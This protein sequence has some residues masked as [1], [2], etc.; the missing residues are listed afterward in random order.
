MSVAKVIE[1]SASS[2][3]GFDDAIRK[4][5]IKV[6]TTVSGMKGARMCEMK[7]VTTPGGAITEYRVR[8]HVSFVVE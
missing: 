1:I 8:M 7:V 3:E 2:H 5:L 6:S 4:G